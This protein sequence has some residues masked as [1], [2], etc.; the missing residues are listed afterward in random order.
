MN[1]FQQTQQQNNDA[2]QD[3]SQT[4]T[5]DQQTVQMPRQQ[6]NG[7]KEEIPAEP[8]GLPS[9]EGA[10]SVPMPEKLVSPSVPEVEISSELHA[11]TGAEA[12]SEIPKLT[13]ED[14]QAG[15]VHAKESVPVLTAPAATIVLPM[16]QQQAQQTVKLHK[17]IKDSLF[18]LAMLVMRQWQ[19]EEKHKK[20]EAA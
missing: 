15:I 20:K 17:K 2:D 11:E 5:D 10:P 18:W 3:V 13:P 8:V 7:R 14:T 12:V 6:E 4:T 9:K 19:I 1:D 16:T